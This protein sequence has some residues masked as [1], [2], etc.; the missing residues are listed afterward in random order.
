MAARAARDPV[1]LALLIWTERFL[2]GGGCGIR[3]SL[4]FH[5]SRSI[6]DLESTPK[7]V[8]VFLNFNRCTD[9]PNP[10]SANM[11]FWQVTGF[12]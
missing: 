11:F 5:L 9:G 3:R 8:Y 6:L 1:V 2:V 7:P 10:N 12:R 4:L